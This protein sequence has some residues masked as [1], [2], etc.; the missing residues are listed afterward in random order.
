MPGSNPF[1][2]DRPAH[3]ILGA[4]GGLGAELAKRLVDRGC[5]V[6]LAG[7]NREELALLADSLECRYLTVD[8]TDFQSMRDCFSQ[9]EVAVGKLDGVANCVGSID[10]KPAHLVDEASWRQTIETNLT[11][12][13]LSVK[14]ASRALRTGG[15]I[16]LVSS[17]AARIGLANHEAIAAAKAGIEGLTRSAAATYARS[18]VRINCVAPGLMRTKLTSS[19]T[20]KEALLKLSTEMHA[21]GRIGEPSDVASLIDWLLCDESSWVTGQC[22]SVDGGLSNV[23]PSPVRTS[24][25]ESKGVS[26]VP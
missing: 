17:C 11:S 22:F 15:S 3:L 14:Y 20:D 9:T 26:T 8:A 24:H 25:S 7:R 1:Q 19:I 21:L 4:N 6:V 18:K 12:A 13:F 2:A 10:L 16:V 23:R 5:T